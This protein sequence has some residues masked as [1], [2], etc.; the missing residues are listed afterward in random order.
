MTIS[1]GGLG[2]TCY[3]RDD[4]EAAESTGNA[5]QVLRKCHPSL[6]RA[7]LFQL[8]DAVA[9]TCQQKKKPTLNF[10]FSHV[11]ST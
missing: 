7:T 1:Q 4:N 3:L 5:A 11:Q 10:K 2:L 9:T 8:D 6:W